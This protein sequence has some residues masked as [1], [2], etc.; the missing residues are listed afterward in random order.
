[1]SQAELARL[2]GIGLRTVSRLARNE[3][4]QVSLETLD[5]LAAVLKV[6]P[7]ELIIREKKARR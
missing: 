6:E 3:T 2:S 5:R 4:G 7:G 1:M